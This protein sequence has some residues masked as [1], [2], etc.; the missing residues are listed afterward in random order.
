MGE[1]RYSSLKQQFPE[2]ADA[3]FDKTA[4]DAA[5]RRDSYKRMEKMYGEMSS[6]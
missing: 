2:I 4:K 1:V 6:K 3:L 5:D